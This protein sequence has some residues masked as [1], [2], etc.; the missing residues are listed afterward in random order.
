MRQPLS[1]LHGGRSVPHGTASCTDGGKAAFPFTR[2]LRRPPSFCRLQ[3][4]AATGRPFRLAADKAA[5][6][7]PF[8]PDDPG[9]RP[10]YDSNNLKE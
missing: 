2:S 3:T 9:G 1:F 7:L 6:R 8:P 5:D 10:P 4:R